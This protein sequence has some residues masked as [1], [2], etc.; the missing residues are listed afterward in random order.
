MFY[1]H[2]SS[3]GQRCRATKQKSSP[4]PKRKSPG[5]SVLE[6]RTKTRNFR[7]LLSGKCHCSTRCKQHHE[8][9]PPTTPQLLPTGRCWVPKNWLGNTSSKK[10]EKTRWEKTRLDEETCSTPSKP[11][12]YTVISNTMH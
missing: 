5:R 6:A 1:R 11:N 4:L 10:K 8:S 12:L 9:L 3:D 2:Q 7:C